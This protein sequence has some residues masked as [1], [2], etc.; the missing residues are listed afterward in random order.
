[1]PTCRICGVEK[2]KSLFP[3]AK[4]RSSGIR[5]ECKSCSREIYKTDKRYKISPE[6]RSEYN[7][8]YMAKHPDYAEKARAAVRASKKKAIES[9]K[10]GS[11]SQSANSEY[12][13]NRYKRSESLRLKDKVKANEYRARKENAL[14]SWA[15]REAI[16]KIYLE[17]K[18]LSEEAGQKFHVDHVVPLKS[19][20]VCGLHVPANLKIVGATENLSK[21]NRWWPDMP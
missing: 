8:R 10:G 3:K 14:P 6:K 2:D 7:E 18:L 9:G 16:S 20:F 1:M 19:D 21:G 4:D 15:D 11:Y 17:A 12:R 13:R 5:K